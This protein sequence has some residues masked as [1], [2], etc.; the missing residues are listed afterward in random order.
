MVI[1]YMSISVAKGVG[2]LQFST[3]FMSASHLYHAAIRVP[4]YVQPQ[5]HL[6]E[7]ASTSTSC[8]GQDRG[9]NKQGRKISAFKKVMT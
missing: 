3:S 5:P 2:Y 4:A 9:N 6:Q 8:A 1:W 7:A